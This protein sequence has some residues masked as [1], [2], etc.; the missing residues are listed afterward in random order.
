MTFQVGDKVKWKLPRKG[1]VTEVGEHYFCVMLGEHNWSF[2]HSEVD[3]FEIV[4][5][6]EPVHGSVAVDRH[7]DAVTRDED[8][9][10]YSHSS[11]GTFPWQ[12]KDLN[13]AYGPLRVVYHFVDTSEG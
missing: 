11:V 1:I 8:G 12:W 3:D 10:R 5:A 2:E 4:S 9:W 6:K 13:D 7:G